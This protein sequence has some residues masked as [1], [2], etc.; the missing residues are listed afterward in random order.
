[1]AESEG[2][3][4]VWRAIREIERADAARREDLLEYGFELAIRTRAPVTVLDPHPGLPHL[5]TM[6]LIPAPLVE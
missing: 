6:W 3:E 4:V 2:S 1:M 5:A